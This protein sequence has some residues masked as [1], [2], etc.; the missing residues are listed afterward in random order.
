MLRFW[1]ILA[2][3]L[4]GS[5]VLMGAWAA[6]GLQ[7]QLSA[8][9]VEI[10][11]TAVHYQMWHAIALL[12]LALSCRE[13]S[14]PLSLKVTGWGWCLGTLLF[15]GSLYVIGLSQGGWLGQWPW[16]LITPLGGLSYVV[17]WASL[18]VYGLKGSFTAKSP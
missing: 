2:A 1:L 5:A 15:S 3:G 7:A 8:H 12:A 18:L 16:A 9:Y 14:A 11:H 10:I 17:G 4:G 13:I 6:H